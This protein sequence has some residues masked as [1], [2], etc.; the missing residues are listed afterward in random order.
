M[1]EPHKAKKTEPP[2]I[3]PASGQGPAYDPMD[4]IVQD[5]QN[6]QSFLD[7]LE[8]K[9]ADA[10]YL[11]AHLPKILGLRRTIA[12]QFDFLAEEPYGYSENL[13]LRLKKE[14]ERLFTYIEGAAGAMKPLKPAELKRF[15][16]ACGKLISQLDDD[17]T[18]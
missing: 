2:T 8:E 7:H 6:I 12:R 1:K 9:P 17:L 10:E 18:P 15:I 14:N 16:D 3:L 11:D 5:L 13:I 4:R